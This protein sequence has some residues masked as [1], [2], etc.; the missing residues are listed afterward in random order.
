M[1]GCRR[2]LC[3]RCGGHVGGAARGGDGPGWLLLTART[4]G[5]MAGSAA[6]SSAQARHR[7][8]RRLAASSLRATHC[9]ASSGADGGDERVLIA[10]CGGGPREPGAHRGTIWGC[11]A[12]VLGR[13]G[14]RTRRVLVLDRLGHVRLLAL[15]VQRVCARRI[16][17]RQV[18]CARR[19]RARRVSRRPVLSVLC[20]SPGSAALRELA[21]EDAV[22]N[23]PMDALDV[24][25]WLRCCAPRSRCR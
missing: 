7:D 16:A 22:E 15:Y 17:R 5:V 18:P 12:L 9:M 19:L 2:L 14:P 23:T 20:P 25:C 21:I 13:L 6:C 3:L 11:S 8:W 10:G 4:A 24:R 1:V